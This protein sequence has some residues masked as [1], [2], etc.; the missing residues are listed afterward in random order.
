MYNYYQ[1]LLL[2]LLLTCSP[3][4]AFL[5]SAVYL[6]MKKWL[7]SLGLWVGGWG[8]ALARPTWTWASGWVG[9]IG[10]WGWLGRSSGRAVGADWA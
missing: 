4:E 1:L 2:L 7:A 9:F 5:P 8:L 3:K 10:R 6:M